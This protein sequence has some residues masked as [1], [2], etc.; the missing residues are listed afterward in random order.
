MSHVKKQYGA[1][2]TLIFYHDITTGKLFDS[3][4]ALLINN[5]YQFS[6]IGTINSNF[7]AN[8]YYEY[9]LEYPE[10]VGYNR[11]KQKIDLAS[12]TTAQ[13]SSDIGYK[14]IHIDFNNGSWGGLSRSLSTSKTVF[15]GS[16]GIGDEYNSF[17]YSIGAL[18]DYYSKNQ[19]P[20]PPRGE[21][22]IGV[23]KC[24]LWLRIPTRYLLS[25]S[26]KR[27]NI[28]FYLSFVILLMCK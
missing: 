27:S 2:W 8:N 1:T 19:F 12:T 24:Y 25:R 21:N 22:S 17:W 9:L 15:D 18:T 20:G 3:T 23:H 11:W 26:Y 28:H 13:K 5:E 10:L 6:I 7:K 14:G 16:P 4:T